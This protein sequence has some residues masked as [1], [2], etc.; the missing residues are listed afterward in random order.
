M[1]FMAFQSFLASPRVVRLSIATL[2]IG[3]LVT[4][5]E[6]QQ[7]LPYGGVLSEGQVDEQ[8]SSE[9]SEARVG[10]AGAVIGFSGSQVSGTQTITLVNTENSGWLCIM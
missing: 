1:R 7:S 2:V 8:S 9:P 6:G 3:A 5:G 4:S 10:V